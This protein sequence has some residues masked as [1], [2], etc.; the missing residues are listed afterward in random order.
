[1]A[2]LIIGFSNCK[3]NWWCFSIHYAWPTRR[4]DSWY[5]SI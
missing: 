2:L 3:L 4:Q 5:W 1:M